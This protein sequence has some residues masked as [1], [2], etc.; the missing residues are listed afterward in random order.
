MITSGDSPSIPSASSVIG[1]PQ[2]ASAPSTTSPRSRPAL[3]GS[4]S[5]AP[6]ISIEL[7]SLMS[8]TMA[9]PIGPTP[10]CTARILFFTMGSVAL[11]R[12]IAF[13]RRPGR[14]FVSF[15]LGANTIM[16]TRG[17]FNGIRREFLW[18]GD[19]QL[20][21]QWLRADNAP[22]AEQRRRIPWQRQ[23]SR[24]RKLQR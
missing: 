18:H 22:D 6:M 11:F 10:Y 1:T 14:R 19:W 17:A 8:R 9:A 7:F 3:A 13:R 24:N 23:N 4:E 16:Q 12:G 2:G 15:Q 20:V 5:I 21:R